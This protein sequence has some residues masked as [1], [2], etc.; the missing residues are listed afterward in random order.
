MA[1]E[2]IPAAARGTSDTGATALRA[3]RAAGGKGY[4]ALPSPV[5]TFYLLAN[6]LFSGTPVGFHRLIFE[7]STAAMLQLRE[8]PAT[9][10]RL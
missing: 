4:T 8:K 3:G 2:T 6:A 1:P 10:P 7:Q 5:G 9:L